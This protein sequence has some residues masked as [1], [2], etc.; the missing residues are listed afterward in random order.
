MRAGRRSLSGRFVCLLPRNTPASPVVAGV[1]YSALSHGLTKLTG[2]FKLHCAQCTSSV[3]FDSVRCICSR[4][5]R[6]VGRLTHVVG[7]RNFIVGRTGVELRGL[8]DHRR[9]A[10][11]VIDSGLGIAGGCIHRVE[12]LLC[13]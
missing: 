11:V 10:N 8:K 9:M 12:D 6:F 7:A 3:A 1:V 13:V 4:G 2:H 5:D